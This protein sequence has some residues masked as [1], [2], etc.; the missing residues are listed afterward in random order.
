MMEAES[1]DEYIKKQKQ[2]L[3]KVIVN[4]KSSSTPTSATVTWTHRTTS[5][6]VISI[7]TT[8]SVS[9]DGNMKDIRESGEVGAPRIRP[10]TKVPGILVNNPLE[11]AVLPD[12]SKEARRLNAMLLSEKATFMSKLEFARKLRSKAENVAALVMQTYYR[13]YHVL[14][15][16]KTIQ[17]NALLRKK[18]RSEIMR[19]LSARPEAAEA[20]LRLHSNMPGARPRAGLERLGEY[21][22]AYTRT[23]NDMAARIQRGYRCFLSRRL[24]RNKKLEIIPLRR[25][26]LI[27]K[28]QCIIRRFNA[29]LRVRMMLRVR[30]EAAR[31][32]AALV[33]QKSYRRRHARAVVFRRRYKMHFVAARMIQTWFRGLASMQRRNRL[34]MFRDVV[35]RNVA[36]FKIQRVARRYMCRSMD[37]LTRIRR[38]RHF[39]RRFKSAVAIQR[40]ARRYNARAVGTRLRKERAAE[41]ELEKTRRTQTEVDELMAAQ[42]RESAEEEEL[43]LATNIFH[44]ARLGHVRE[45]VDLYQMA[46]DGGS[47]LLPHLQT[48]IDDGGAGDTVLLVAATHGWKELVF[49]CL[50]RDASGMNPWRF[51]V[52]YRNPAGETA[53]MLAVKYNRT[54]IVRYLLAEHYALGSVPVPTEANAELDAGVPEGG[55]SVQIARISTVD[56]A[57]ML[58]YA[59]EHGHDKGNCALLS[60]L[61]DARCDV[62]A[63]H[64][65]TD[66]TILHTVCRLGNNDMYKLVTGTAELKNMEKVPVAD[67]HTFDQTGVNTCGI[68]IRSKDEDG[69]THLHRACGTNNLN[70]IMNLLNVVVDEEGKYINTTA[71]EI[72]VPEE[73]P[74]EASA[75]AEPDPAPSQGQLVKQLSR[76]P[77]GRS[78]VSQVLSRTPSVRGEIAAPVDGGDGAD[79]LETVASVD[80]NQHEE[81]DEL[82]LAL[83]AERVEAVRVREEL[84]QAY[85]SYNS[86]WKRRITMTDVNGKDCLLHAALHGQT[87][88]LVLLQE[89]VYQEDQEEKAAAAAAKAAAE[90]EAAAEAERLADEAAAAAEAAPPMEA[91]KEETEKEPNPP[92]KPEGAGDDWEA[93]LGEGADENKENEVLAKVLADAEAKERADEEE[94]AAKLEEERAAEE[95]KRNAE[96]EEAAAAKA[97]IEEIGWSPNDITLIFRSI[98]ARGK[99]ECLAYLLKAGF[100][101]AG[102][103]DEPTG[104]NCVMLAAACNQKLVVDMLLEHLAAG[105]E[106]SMDMTVDKMGRNCWFYAAVALEG[107]GMIPFL[108]SHPHAAKVSLSRAGLTLQDN[109]G[110]NVLHTAIHESVNIISSAELLV[111]SELKICAGQKDSTYGLTPLLLACSMKAE[112][113]IALLLELDTDPSVRD[114]FQH[115]AMWHLWRCGCVE[116]PTWSNFKYNH[117]PD[118]DAAPTTTGDELVSFDPEDGYQAVGDAT[119]IALLRAGCSLFTYAGVNEF[120]P[121]RLKPL[122]TSVRVKREASKEPMDRAA[123]AEYTPYRPELGTLCSA[124]KGSLDSMEAAEVLVRKRQFEVIRLLVQEEHRGLISATDAWRI[125]LLCVKYSVTCPPP[126]TPVAPA[127]D[128]GEEEAAPVKSNAAGGFDP[129]INSLT[130]FLACGGAEVMAGVGAGVVAEIGSTACATASDVLV[131]QLGGGGSSALVTDVY[132]DLTGYQRALCRLMTVT[133]Y[134]YTL[135]GW[136][137]LLAP[138]SVSRVSKNRSY[139]YS[140]PAA[141][142]FEHY[143]YRKQEVEVDA[144]KYLLKLYY[145]ISTAILGRV[146]STGQ[147]HVGAAATSFVPGGS[148]CFSPHQPVD[149]HGNTLSHLVSLMDIP[150][151]LDVLHHSF[152]M[153]AALFAGHF[154]KIGEA[155]GGGRACTLAISTEK[156]SVPVQLYNVADATVLNH[157]MGNVFGH[158]AELLSTIYAGATFNARLCARFQTPP[159]NLLNSTYHAHVL[160]LVRA[161]ELGSSSQGT[162]DAVGEAS[163]EVKVISV[164][165]PHGHGHGGQI[166][167]VRSSSSSTLSAAGPAPAVTNSNSTSSVSGGV[168][169]A[170]I[171]ASFPLGVFDRDDETYFSTS[172]DPCFVSHYGVTDESSTSTVS[173]RVIPPGTTGLFITCCYCNPKSKWY[174]RNAGGEAKGG[175]D[176]LR[177]LYG[178]KEPIWRHCFCFNHSAGCA[179][180]LSHKY[181]SSSVQDASA[182]SC[183]TVGSIVYNPTKIDIKAPKPEGGKKK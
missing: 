175:V 35:R 9:Q 160:A 83:E 128:E 95:A 171:Q 69:L 172:P 57:V 75:G 13:R 19:R 114:R 60:L 141:A 182:E 34:T 153:T 58:K 173:E 2:E 126:E 14:K 108:L 147:V 27:I 25:F 159:R 39:V 67:T 31:A 131:A 45:V 1:C 85:L 148:L 22:A 168:G 88:V 117:V 116:M 137:V 119:I 124:E 179:A 30:R 82:A 177:A 76:V 37:R 81:V 80:S 3:Q 105:D 70:M 180:A 12:A 84:R 155:V 43:L 132:A 36:T 7:M 55:S 115:N 91:E 176:R 144:L 46:V 107:S 29:R 123:V 135:M 15:H 120:A 28:I 138:K 59:V 183:F 18:Y 20:L 61:L 72:P 139:S 142:Q 5:C 121:F 17:R 51:D 127:D 178:R 99:T 167:H 68:D 143:Y 110:W 50:E 181:R 152:G 16:F 86:S 162:V 77:S 40:A 97:A 163:G 101:P 122:P 150:V 157:R 8:A 26:M 65:L 41:Q 71:E 166:N 62:T 53:L 156:P 158:S 111:K 125:A 73:E 54:E 100:D 113:Q 38:R 103:I 146:T 169:I 170:N 93:E 49:K 118:A 130:D 66:E 92:L 174:L 164:L 44:H 136:A 4:V 89:L 109:F 48:D 33:I 165:E 47:L 78:D 11:E 79:V 21:R 134:G 87:E 52:N 112:D 98:I 64:P 145:V 151:A 56:G 10:P 23:R 6:D 140:G 94:A 42:V 90:E 149:V 24:L 154:A 96:E 129:A 32:H 102:M 74:E 104:C 63:T 106:V 133:Y 161:S